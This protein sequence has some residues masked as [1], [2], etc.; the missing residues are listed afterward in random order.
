MYSVTII[1]DDR[2]QRELLAAMIMR[3][4]AAAR[5]EFM[6]ASA[7]AGASGPLSA[8]IALVD[9]D[10]GEDLPSG[11]DL[12]RDTA[13]NKT[14]VIYVTGYVDYV[15]DVY[16]TTHV[17]FLIKPV[18]QQRLNDALA[19]AISRLEQDGAGDFV[20]HTGSST[21]R[22]APNRVV[23]I[24]SNRRKLQIH[25][26]GG[27]IIETYGKL[28]DVAQALPAGFARCHQSFLVNQ[29]CVKAIRASELVLTDGTLLPVSQRCRKDLLRAFTLHVG[30][31]L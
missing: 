24:E 21:L 1:D 5:L 17:G 20:V 13:A 7:A 27:R 30:R 12:V 6:D 31:E 25:E 10:L 14:Q 18:D 19:R 2:A 3:S 9:I 11:I 29:S 26:G 23:Y 8:D 4:P 16:E 22:V 15:S 28:S